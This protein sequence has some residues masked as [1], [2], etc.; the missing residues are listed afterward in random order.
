M[1]A[2]EFLTEDGGAK[3]PTT[4]RDL[5]YQ[6]QDQRWRDAS[7]QRRIERTR[8]MYANHAW[9]REQLELERMR[10]ELDQL[11]A[12]TEAIKAETRAAND[13]AISGLARSGSEAKQ[14]DHERVRQLA[15]AAI[16]RPK[17]T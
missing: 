5:N 2:W 10:L 16:R 7:H 3:P 1:R 6:K 8:G 12:E 15:R 14:H 11:K 17:K 4:L 13:D 9:Q